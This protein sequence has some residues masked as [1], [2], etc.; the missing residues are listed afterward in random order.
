MF[1]QRCF[2]GEAVLVA[3]CTCTFG[4]AQRLL[5]LILCSS[6]NVRHR[7]EDHRAL[8]VEDGVPPPRAAPPLLRRVVLSHCADDSLR[9][10][11]PAFFCVL[12]GTQEINHENTKI[13][14]LCP[15]TFSL[16]ASKLS[17]CTSACLTHPSFLRLELGVAIDVTECHV[18]HSASP[19]PTTPP[20]TQAEFELNW[21]PFDFNPNA[22]KVR[23]NKLKMY[24]RN[25]GQSHARLPNSSHYQ[26][27]SL[28][29]SS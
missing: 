14:V 2:E 29:S 5:T 24:K 28:P 10:R 11:A 26:H 16:R 27:D 22:P 17:P 19:A 1:W 7:T 18:W 20:H 12:F 4:A 3:H 8:D 25:S 9:L 23:T 15:S 13:F 6:D 21:R